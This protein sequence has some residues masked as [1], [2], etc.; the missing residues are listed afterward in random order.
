MQSVAQWTRAHNVSRVLLVSDPFHM[1]RLRLEAGHSSL[2][3]FTSPTHSSPISANW[4][5]ELFFLASEAWKIP[6]VLVRGGG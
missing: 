3:A 5:S 2:K 4:R 1:L 6:V